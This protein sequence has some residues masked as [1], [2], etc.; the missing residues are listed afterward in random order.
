MMHKYQLYSELKVSTFVMNDERHWKP[1]KKRLARRFWSY[2]FID[3][4]VKILKFGE[5]IGLERKRERE[6]EREEEVEVEGNQGNRWIKK[7][8]LKSGIRRSFQIWLASKVGAV[9]G[10]ES[11]E[12]WVF[13]WK[14]Y[15]K[16]FLQFALHAANG[17]WQMGVIFL[18]G[19]VYITSMLNRSIIPYFQCFEAIE[20][21]PCPRSSSL[22]RYKFWIMLKGYL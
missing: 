4:N 1:T 14:I 15:S 21:S 7:R 3:Y 10:K 17:K 2:T 5:S 8:E 12:T 9:N 13:F 18:C 20:K 22:V 6:R 11:R 16:R 19:T